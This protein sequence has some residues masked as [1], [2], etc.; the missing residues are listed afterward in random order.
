MF[1][2]RTTE[3]QNFLF[4]HNSIW[5]KVCLIALFLLAALIR[6]DEIKAPGHLIVREYNSAI[7]A[8]AFYMH[9]NDNVE[10]WRRDIA[11][12]ARDQ[13][14]ML[15]PPLTE[16]LV[17]LIYRIAGG[18]EIWYSRYLTSLFWLI[19][20]IFLYK[21]VQALVSVEAALI[22]TGYYLFAPWSIIISRSF[23]PDSLMMMMFMISLYI[24]VRYFQE[25]SWRNLI[26]ALG[27]SLVKNH[28][29]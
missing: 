8:R 10:P 26:L 16:Y 9:G 12:A 15:E 13:L 22:G 29:K 19:G 11:F 27:I 25:P 6:R 5:L 1:N 14:P 28:N 21:T 4:G 23:Q 7:F 20:G 18:E 24:I 3:Q 17:S 2:T